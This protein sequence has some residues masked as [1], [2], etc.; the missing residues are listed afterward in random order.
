MIVT[1]CL[2]R[3]RVVQ[4]AQAEAWCRRGPRPSRV[5]T[6]F[7]HL[8]EYGN[9][10]IVPLHPLLQYSMELMRRQHLQRKHISEIQKRSQV[11]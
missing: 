1:A 3:Q 7:P 2:I 11:N 9:I 8:H 10:G 4:A 5:H 6:V